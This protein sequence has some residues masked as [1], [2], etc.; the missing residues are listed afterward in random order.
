[1][2]KTASG[3]ILLWDVINGIDGVMLQTKECTTGFLD[4]EVNGEV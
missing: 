1:V 2:A 4:G 3:K